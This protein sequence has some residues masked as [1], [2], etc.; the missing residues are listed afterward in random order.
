MTAQIFV[1][2]WTA[3]PWAVQITSVAGVFGLVFVV[4]TSQALIVRAYQR[5][6]HCGRL[7][8]AL[9]I[10]SLALAGWTV[11]RLG[12]LPSRTVR[13]AAA[14]WTW[15]DLDRTRSR[16][17][18]ALMANLV[19]PL[20]KQAAERGARLVIF[21]EVSFWLDNNSRPGVLAAL[22]AL[23]RKHR[24]ML[25]V[26]YFHKERNDNHAAFI[27]ATGA[28]RSE[29]VKTHLIPFSRTTGRGPAPPR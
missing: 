22:R 23:A 13:V 2:V 6:E 14:G 24:V 16:G 18:G 8:A 19:S 7:A 20:V 1:R 5:R 10:L 17:N 3:A 26:G 29:Y 28:L 21:P 25:V 27:D 12:Q 15:D 9:C 11:A 4:V